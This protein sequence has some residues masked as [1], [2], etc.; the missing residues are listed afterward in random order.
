MKIKEISP[1]NLALLNGFQYHLKVEKGLSPNSVESYYRDLRDFLLF[2]QKKT[3]TIQ[4]G[5]VI[6]YFVNLQGIGISNSSI[7]R[8]RSSI[9]SFFKFLKEEEIEISINLDDI[10]KIKYSQKLPDVLSVKEM[11]RLLDNIPTESMNGLRNKAML[12]LMYAS[13]LRISEAINLSI[14]DVNW[15]EKV[16]R[17]MGKGG[18]Q[19]VVPVAEI[20]ME[21]VKRYF[22]VSRPLLKKE[23]NTDYFFLNRSGNKLSRMGVWKIIDNLSKKAGIKKHVSPHT[24][25]HSFATHLLEAGAN[26]RVVQMLLGHASINT[27]QI[28]TNIGTSFIVKEHRLYHPRG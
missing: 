20:S 16:I 23:K 25:R 24:F 8:K 22:D 1:H 11:F 9:K 13:G 26:L 2:V 3:E 4:T 19:R 17:V 15:D 21:F 12:E 7:A 18:K 14:H 28:Y 6:N 27:T 10:P 5:D